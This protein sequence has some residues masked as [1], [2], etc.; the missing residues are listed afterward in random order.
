MYRDMSFSNKTQIRHIFGSFIES[1]IF[2]T[3]FFFLKVSCIYTSV[4]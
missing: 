3:E 4:Q 2:L 1:K